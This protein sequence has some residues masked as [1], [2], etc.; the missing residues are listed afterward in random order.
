M[1]MGEG[2]EKISTMAREE[3][4]SWKASQQLPSN[5]TCSSMDIAEDLRMYLAAKTILPKTPDLFTERRILEICR[6]VEL[7]TTKDSTTLEEVEALLQAT[8]TKNTR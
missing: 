4:T 5:S 6:Q 1:E 8:R 7:S 2:S 3:S